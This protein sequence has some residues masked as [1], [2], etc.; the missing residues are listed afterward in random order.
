MRAGKMQAEEVDIDVSL[1]PGARGAVSAVARRPI[2]PVD[3]GHTG[4]TRHDTQAR[5]TS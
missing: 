5:S 3:A 2:E 1:G 4:L